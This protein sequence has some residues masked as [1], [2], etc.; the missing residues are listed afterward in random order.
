MSKFL[1]LA[2]IQKLLLQ[3]FDFILHRVARFRIKL[4][5]DVEMVAALSL[6]RKKSDGQIKLLLFISEQDDGHVSIFDAVYDGIE[7]D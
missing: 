3:L 1:W 5:G 6:C 2:A 4:D 7:S